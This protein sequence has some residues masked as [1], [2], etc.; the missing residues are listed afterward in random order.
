MVG[1]K[2]MG[3]HLERYFNK[4]LDRYTNLCKRHHEL[5]RQQNMVLRMK[6]REHQAN[7]EKKAKAYDQALLVIVKLKKELK[8]FKSIVK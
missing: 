6:N 7:L 5:H 2:I 8:K 1:C 4:D 3:C